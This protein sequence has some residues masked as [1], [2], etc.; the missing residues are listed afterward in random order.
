[1]SADAADWRACE[2]TAGWECAAEFNHAELSRES[3]LHHEGEASLRVRFHADARWWHCGGVQRRFAPPLDLSGSGGFA[4]W[5]YNPDAT[6]KR[7]FSFYTSGGAQYWVRHSQE[8]RWLAYGANNQCLLPAGP[9]WKQIDFLFDEIHGQDRVT[10]VESRASLHA[11]DR[12]VIVVQEMGEEDRDSEFLLD[13]ISLLPRGPEAPLG[14]EGDRYPAVYPAGD[15][16]AAKSAALLSEARRL[17]ADGKLDAAATVLDEALALSPGH[18]ETRREVMAVYLKMAPAARDA[19]KARLRAR[20]DAVVHDDLPLAQGYSALHQDLVDAWSRETPIAGFRLSVQTIGPGYQFTTKTKLVETAEIIRDL[21]ADT[22]KLCLATSAYGLPKGD[23]RSLADLAACEPSFQAVLQMPFRHVLLWVYPMSAGSWWLDGTGTPEQRRADYREIYDL[24][25][26]LLKTFAGTGK[27]FYLGNWEGDWHLLGLGASQAEPSE[28]R[29]AGM[30]EWFNVRQQAVD[31]AK[32]D[33]PHAGVEVY[34]YLEVNDVPTAMRGAP[35]LSNRVL[36]Y[37]HVDYVSYSSYSTTGTGLC[38]TGKMPEA[39]PA[40][41]DFIER[42]LPPKD[43]PG[44]RV[45]IGEFGFPVNE[46]LTPELQDRYAA[47]VARAAL[48]WGCPFIL[49]WELYCN[50]YSQDRH[51]F[52]GFWLI[53]D[54]NRPQ[55]VYYRMKRFLQQAREYHARTGDAGLAL[56][57]YGPAAIRW[58]EE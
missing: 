4:V 23:Y 14:A 13:D 16:R 57:K 48:K 38:R 58:L 15:A 44:K 47:E 24:T 6:R 7:I 3:V 31:D 20:Y 52:N 51:Q 22:I 18:E 10:P 46:G 8:P 28:G 11:V 2:D 43:L 55:P 19:W 45:W 35:R 25:A 5:V 41:L 29:I 49:Y 21:G 1:M 27:R 12:L 40:A 56:D 53:D 42:N 26:Y 17:L 34:H 37:T 50:E 39:L 54:K 32:R 36:P 9:G 33:T 30:T